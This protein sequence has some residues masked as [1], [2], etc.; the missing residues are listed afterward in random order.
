MESVQS[1][2]INMTIIIKYSNAHKID[3]VDQG[4]AMYDP[5]SSPSNFADTKVFESVAWSSY[6]K[7]YMAGRRCSQHT[8]YNTCTNVAA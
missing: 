2:I 6:E 5:T 1:Y 3:N 7:W 4:Q 8:M